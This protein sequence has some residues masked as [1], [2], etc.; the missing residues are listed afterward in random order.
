M[1]RILIFANDD[2]VIYKCRKELV[3]K[4]LKDYEVHL[5]IKKFKWY[6]ELEKMGCKITYIDVDRNGTNIKNDIK[7]FFEYRKIKEK[8]NPDV[9]LTYNI[10]PNIYANLFSNCKKQIAIVNIT[11]L[12]KAVENVGILQ[13]LTVFL[14]K[15]A[16]KNVRCIFFQNQE[17]M[18]FFKYRSIGNYDRYKLLP[19]SG[20]NLDQYQVLPYPDENEGIHFLFIARVMKE[21]GIEE[22]FEAAKRIKEKHP[23]TF[24]H[25]LGF[26]EENYKEKLEKYQ[27]Q[28]IILYE[29][30]QEDILKFQKISHCTIH[31]SYYPEG[32]SNVCLESAAC[33][34]PVITTDRSGCRET[35]DNGETGYIIKQQ[36]VDDLVEKIE[37]FLSLPYEE[38]RQMGLNGRAKMEKQFD[39]QIIIDAYIDEINNILK[40]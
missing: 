33:G 6:D 14:Y 31:P 15:I 2:L 27:K 34:R 32:M 5:C 26:C 8:I 22:Y 40:N 36:D 18:N 4:L 37:R 28:G 1:N 17:N 39:R 7:L 13:K 21:K 23:N 10:K 35:V 3:Q 12:G 38:K 20:V 19:G 16:M 25:V 30:M 24:F 9:I 29:G 11:G